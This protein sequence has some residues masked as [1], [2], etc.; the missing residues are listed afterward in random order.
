MPKINNMSKSVTFPSYIFYRY[1][2]KIQYWRE[3]KYQHI[4]S[5]HEKN[6]YVRSKKIERYKRNVHYRKILFAKK[7]LSLQLFEIY[8]C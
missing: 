3:E 2:A 4:I 8:S 5:I 6:I 7:N 1:I